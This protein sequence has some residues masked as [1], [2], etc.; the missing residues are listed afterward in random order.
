MTSPKMAKLEA[1]NK[2]LR[3]Q[4]DFQKK[5][6]AS[7]LELEQEYARQNH[8]N[9]A[10]LYKALSKAAPQMLKE[11][12]LHD[13]THES[14]KL[15]SWALR[16]REAMQKNERL[17]TELAEAKRVIGEIYAGKHGCIPSPAQVYKPGIWLIKRINEHEDHLEW[18]MDEAQLK[19][20]K[21]TQLPF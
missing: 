14:D 13:S 6:S 15:S 16:Y 18:L 4:L 20:L 8:E 7:R 1:E 17:E 19:R 3:T 21:D 2:R 12:D 10:M 11:L 5:T 9:A